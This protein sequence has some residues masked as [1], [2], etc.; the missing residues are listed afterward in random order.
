ML[1][2]TFLF[3]FALFG[4]V[5]QQADALLVARESSTTG[6]NTNLRP[7]VDDNGPLDHR[8]VMCEL[9]N[10]S[11]QKLARRLA[12]TN[13]R[14]NRRAP[15][16]RQPL[17][18][19]RGPTDAD[20][21]EFVDD[22][23]PDHAQRLAITPTQRQ[24]DTWKIK[25]N[26]RDVPVSTT[27]VRRSFGDKSQDFVVQGLSGCT[28]IIIISSK[29]IWAGHIWEGSGKEYGP[30]DL[31]N[32]ERDKAE[33]QKIAVDI[34]GARTSSRV[35]ADREL[36]KSLVDLR[37]DD[38]DP[39]GQ[40]TD[41][42]IFLLTQ[43]KSVDD[44]AALYRGHVD[45]LRAKLEQLIPQ[46]SYTERTYIRSSP[47]PPRTVG[48]IGVQY[49]PYD[50]DDENGNGNG[51]CAP[52]ARVR[53]F[54]ENNKQPVIDKSWT[55][56]SMQTGSLR[57]RNASIEW[58]IKQGY[59]AFGDSFAAGMGTGTTTSDSCRIG[60]ANIGDLINA[61]TDDP[62][63]DY[64]RRMCSGDTTVGLDRQIKEWKNPEK[65]DVAT[66]TIGGNDLGFSDIVSLCVLSFT[67]DYITSLTTRC[68]DAKKKAR[69]LMRDTSD[70]GIGTRLVAAYRK[71]LE[72][73]TRKDF[74]LYVS[75]Y[76]SGFFNAETEDCENV[77][78]DWQSPSY[79]SSWTCTRPHAWY[80]YLSIRKDLNDLVVELNDVI[81]AATQKVNTDK[82][83]DQVHFVDVGPL[84][85]NHR[86]C[87][88]SNDPNF[89]EPDEDRANT[90]YFLS[91]WKDIPSPDWPMTASL[92]DNNQMEITALI[93][94][95]SIQLPPAD[96]CE[97]SLGTD[98]DPYAR[99]LCR[100][101]EGVAAEPQGDLAS[102]LREANNEIAAKNI[103][104]QSIGWFTPTKQIE[105][106]HP[107]T[108]GMIA[109]RDSII[110]AINLTQSVVNVD[111][112]ALTY[113]PEEPKFTDAPD[114]PISPAPT[115][116]NTDGLLSPLMGPPG[117]K[118]L[119]P[120]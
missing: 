49:S 46:A 82:G 97:A 4:L 89:H 39:F 90:W 70:N 61:Y 102:K 84:F 57:K 26:N 67:W 18:E 100:A 33:F 17:A 36:W 98:P 104:G 45:L 91:G 75:G 11:P 21:A 87:E 109:Y 96:T 71:S 95:G 28:A 81:S 65:A 1:I 115:T 23:F 113:D 55:P 32:R 117:G 64:Q 52:Q 48:I 3:L 13:P 43:A 119:P 76:P 112:P 79:C 47:I 9:G 34:L 101:S 114:Q 106:F 54:Y 42:D 105:T 68:N 50:H 92:P 12:H 6:H 24:L 14:I 108:P 35:K 40:G 41:V 27:G 8:S 38:G 19:P 86:W 74:H 99:W 25:W 22:T 73:S 88:A 29:G 63:I 16:R 107:R 44:G 60:S 37:Q 53:V 120:S 58:P 118:V 77:T 94:Q 51:Q 2:K 78:F 72:K 7:R 20:F 5:E 15:V 66:L 80:L 10:P 83:V 85:D 111:L 103:T 116:T 93:E 30:G 69:Q 62:N 31:D 56:T 59:V 110:A